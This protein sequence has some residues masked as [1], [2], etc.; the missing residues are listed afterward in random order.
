MLESQILWTALPRSA[1]A[2]HLELDVFVSPRL[3]LDATKD[4]Y[5]LSEFP[6]WEHWTKTLD[7]KIS[8]TVEFADGST[9]GAQVIETEPLDHVAWDSL[10]PP[11]SF[12]RSWSFKDL[13]KLPIYSFPVRFVTAYLRDRYKEIGQAHP[14]RPPGS[15]GLEPLIQDLGPVTDVR[16]PEERKPPPR[17][18]S[19]LPIP[20]GE[21]PE[22]TPTPQ[23]EGCIGFLWRFVRWLNRLIRK[24]L[25]LPPPPTPQ[26][27]DVD[28]TKPK[29][30]VP[31][32]V[33]PSPYESPSP[34][35]PFTPPALAKLEQEMDANKVIDDS[36]VGL[37]ERDPTFNF[38]RALRFYERPESE[39]PNEPPKTDGLD[40]TR[41]RPRPTVP[42]LDFH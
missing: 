8:F 9:V 10:F 24:L 18:P 14:T 29:T 11:D 3:G 34:P 17:D 6:D 5:Q 4:R 39:P 35:D 12:V 16:V 41:V 22:P 26:P 19:D 20:E 15:G 31:H 37:A 2:D 30:R 40:P 1:D 28:P 13:S 33:H 7:E 27:P 36:Q 32:V 21:E 23:P 25:G 38:T 42:E